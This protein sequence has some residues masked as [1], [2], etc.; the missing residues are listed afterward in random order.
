MAVVDTT[1]AHTSAEPMQSYSVDYHDT[2]RRTT[3]SS[4]PHPSEQTPYSLATTDDLP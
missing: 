2:G 1:A 4:L 3:V